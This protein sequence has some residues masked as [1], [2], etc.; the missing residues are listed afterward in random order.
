MIRAKLFKGLI[1]GTM[2][3]GTLFDD[4]KIKLLSGC[5][6]NYCGS[7]EHLALDHI[8]AKKFGGKDAGDNL[9]YACRSCNSSK[10]KKWSLKTGVGLNIVT[11]Y[12]AMNAENLSLYTA[13]GGSYLDAEIENLSITENSDDFMGIGIDFNQKIVYTPNDTNSFSFELRNLNFNYLLNQTAIYVDTSLR[14]NGVEYD[15]L[16]DSSSIT[17]FIDSSY[18]SVVDRGRDKKRFTLLPTTIS[19]SWNRRLNEKSTLTAQLTAVDLGLYGITT[20]VGLNHSFS[21]RLRV[22]S[23]LGYGTFT[24]LVW[25]EAAEYRTRS[26]YSFYARIVGLNAIA[27]PNASKN[28]GFGFGLAKQF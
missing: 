23:K 4:E 28:Y 7:I 12:R 1:D 27:L 13:S 19:L 8:F 14:F 9:I 16:N 3:I 21:N 10:G 20:T 18:N 5:K 24:G 25:E 15:F 22:H 11:D 6:C 26:G 2:N 17:E